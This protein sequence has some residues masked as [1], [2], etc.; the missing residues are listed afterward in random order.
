[1]IGVCVGSLVLCCGLAWWQWQR[2]ESANGTFQNLGY[3]LQ[4]PL[5]GIAPAYM[6]WR[7]RTLRAQHE[8]EVAP[9]PVEPVVQAP[10][11]LDYRVPGDRDGHEDP[12]DAERAEYNR[13]L[14]RLNAQYTQESR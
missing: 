2:F 8:A 11:A 14:A 5:F 1:M 10:T 4:W 9:V 13:Y 6:F 3:V 12:E 7:M